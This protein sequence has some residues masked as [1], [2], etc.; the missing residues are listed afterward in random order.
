MGQTQLRNL[1]ASGIC[2]GFGSSPSRSF[3]VSLD[4]QDLDPVADFYR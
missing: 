3:Q 1:A 2:L 4:N